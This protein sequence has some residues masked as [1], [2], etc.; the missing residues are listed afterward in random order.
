MMYVP[1]YL[2]LS[3]QQVQ[4]KLANMAEGIP[5]HAIQLIEIDYAF[6]KDDPNYDGGLSFLDRIGAKLGIF[7]PHWNL[8]QM[9]QNIITADDRE[10]AYIDRII[11]MFD[12]PGMKEYYGM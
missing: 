12:R 9:K 4:D 10:N 2:Q 5:V 8:V 7:H 11:A 3:I 1:E 6:H